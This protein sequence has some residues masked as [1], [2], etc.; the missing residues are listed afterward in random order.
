PPGGSLRQ[1]GRLAPGMQ[2][3]RVVGLAVALAV[4]VLGPR[5]P[6]PF[7]TTVVRSGDR[8]VAPRSAAAAPDPK[9]PASARQRPPARKAAARLRQTAR[10]LR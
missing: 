10:A 6:L 9:R 1:R 7:G 4:A 3:G 5:A 8:I 2:L